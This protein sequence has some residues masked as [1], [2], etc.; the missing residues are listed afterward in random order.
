MAVACARRPAVWPGLAAGKCCF[1]DEGGNDEGMSA[2]NISEMAMAV[3]LCICFLVLL[4]RV[5]RGW[6][7]EGQLRQDGSKVTR[8][9]LALPWWPY[10]DASRRGVIRGLAAAIAAAW[11]MLLCWI[12]VIIAEHSSGIFRQ[13]MHVVA[14]AF[15]CCF[16]IFLLLHFIVVF[17]NKP[18]FIVPPSQ[19]EEPGLFE[20]RQAK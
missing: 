20:K 19:R 9:D 13:A 11:S 8:G 12:A 15:L 16:A 4:L 10:S 6:F 18:K 14:A 1:Y 17:F 7:S 3:L 2:L 5:W